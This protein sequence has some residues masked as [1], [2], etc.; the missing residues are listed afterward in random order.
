MVAILVVFMFVALAGLGL[1][2]RRTALRKALTAAVRMDRVAYHPGHM[3]TARVGPSLYKTGVDDVAASLAGTPE[4]IEAPVPGTQVF[5]DVRQV[6]VRAGDRSLRLQA[7]L[8]G[9]VVAVNAQ[10]MGN[11]SIVARDPFGTGWLYIVRSDDKR[12]YARLLTGNLARNW[13]DGIRRQIADVIWSP[14][15][16]AAWDAGPLRPGYG[17]DLTSEQFDYLKHNLMD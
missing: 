7:P 9:R 15:A 11:P 5:Q 14:A 2:H 8:S 13:L 6:T 1:W 12:G 17:D 16:A 4:Q 3:W 10:A